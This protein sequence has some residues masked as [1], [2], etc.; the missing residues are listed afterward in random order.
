VEALQVLR[1]TRRTA[2]RCRRASLQPLHNTIV[3]AP[4]ELRDQV[5]NLTRMQR[6]R[7][8]AAWRP[9]IIAYRDPVVATKIAMRSLARRVLG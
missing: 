1:T 7:T 2:V 4:E 5:R 8:C 3:A 6:L 9:D